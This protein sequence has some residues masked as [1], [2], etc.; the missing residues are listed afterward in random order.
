MTHQL[1]KYT[2]QHVLHWHLFL[3]QYG[4]EFK[5]IPGLDNVIAD[6]FSAY[7]P[8]SSEE[9]SSTSNTGGVANA[10]AIT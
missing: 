8:R 4:C 9:E 6:A 7:L 10:F 5:Y 2:M 1:R 3:E